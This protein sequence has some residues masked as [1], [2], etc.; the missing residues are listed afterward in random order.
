MANENYQSSIKPHLFVISN[1]P[2][3]ELVKHMGT[4]SVVKIW[5]GPVLTVACVWYLFITLSN[6]NLI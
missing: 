1:R 3:E 5:C 2:E 4:W 6:M